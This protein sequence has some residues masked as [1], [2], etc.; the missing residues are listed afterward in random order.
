MTTPT[1]DRRTPMSSSFSMMRG[2]TDS[3]EEV[4]K[5]MKISSLITVMKRQIPKPCHQAI[6]PS[7]TNTNSRQA[8]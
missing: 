6:A 4:P 2:S 7:T 5:T 3:D 8:R 1:T